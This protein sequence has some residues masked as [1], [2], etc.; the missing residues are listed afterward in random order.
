MKKY[1][2]LFSVFLSCRINAQWTAVSSGTNNF[3][4]ALLTQILSA[5]CFMQEGILL[6][7]PLLPTGS[8]H[9]TELRGRHLAQE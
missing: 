5:T 4:H 8:L 7:L 3:V 9:G 2:L 6:P 1:L